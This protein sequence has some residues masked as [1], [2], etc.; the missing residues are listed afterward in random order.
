MTSAPTLTQHVYERL[1]GQLL[2]GRLDARQQLVNRVIARELGT[3]TI[4][5]REAIQRLASE[6]LVEYV[7]GAGAFV[8]Q[9]D[10][11]EL[12]QLYD[13]REALE[14]LAAAE[15]ARNIATFELDELQAFCD[16][17]HALAQAIPTRGHASRKQMDEWLDLEER[18][19]AMLAAAT[20]N[21]WLER[22]LNG[23]RLVALVCAAQRGAPSLLTAELARQT[24]REHEELVQALRERAVEKARTWMA[25]HIRHGRGVVLEY[26][27]GKPTPARRR[28]KAE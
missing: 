3:S 10:R 14:P 20:R 26:F 17:W 16:S 27:D 1:R 5:V 15:A 12:A 22:M 13:L 19:H 9:P 8:R 24:C 6:G 21:P 23:L 7:P 11:R 2:S 25:Q 4:P 28:R 18:F